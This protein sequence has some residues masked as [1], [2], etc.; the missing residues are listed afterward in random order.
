MISARGVYIR[1]TADIIP[2]LK[3]IRNA[4]MKE[5]YAIATAAKMLEA[6]R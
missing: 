5:L 2:N 1:N 6:I 3:N 4:D